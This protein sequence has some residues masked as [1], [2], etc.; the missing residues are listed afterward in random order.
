MCIHACYSQ[1]RAIVLGW[2][3]F[4]YHSV[5]LNKGDALLISKTLRE[6]PSEAICTLISFH[7][8]IL[9]DFLNCWNFCEL[10]H[11]STMS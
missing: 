11:S 1:R 8:G 2:L 9:L 7:I 4:H 5:C 6:H 3:F 10:F